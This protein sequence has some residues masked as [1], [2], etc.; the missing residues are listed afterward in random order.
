M[1]LPLIGA[2]NSLRWLA[3]M[4]IGVDGITRGYRDGAVFGPALGSI[5]GASEIDGSG[6]T[7]IQI[8][9]ET[10][11]PSTTISISGI[12]GLSQTAAAR[13]FTINGV[14]ASTASAD[15]FNDAG[16]YSEWSWLS[17]KFNLAGQTGTFSV[18]IA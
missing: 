7:I 12:T 16:T 2:G 14:T 11:T 9:Y 6:E 10:T 15:G 17:D 1:F 5:S 13:S 3:S 8:V 18:H 4:T